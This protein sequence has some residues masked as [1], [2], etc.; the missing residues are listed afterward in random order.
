MKKQGIGKRMGWALA[1]V[2][3]CT[4]AGWSQDYAT[5][6]NAYRDDYRKKLYA[7]SKVVKKR[8]IHRVQFYPVQEAGRVE[9]VFR[10]TPD[11]VP[12]EM[13]TSS[14][15]VKPFV[16]YG[17]V[18]FSWGGTTQ[19]LEVYRNPE[20]TLPQYRSH[21]FIPFKDLTNGV[22]SYEGGR[23]LDALV[24]DI[25]GDRLWLDFNKAYNPYCVYSDDW[26]CPIP[27]RENHLSVAI[28]AG[29]KMFG[30]GR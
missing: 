26:N 14:G 13:L 30:K 11:T 25:K 8:H 28:A 1:G 7:A 3:L 10:R 19:M 18:T 20:Q 27:P 12:F 24:S 6:L 29:E 22:G 17:E 16:K 4:T 2:V 9:G 5:E 23:Y 21:L 15:N